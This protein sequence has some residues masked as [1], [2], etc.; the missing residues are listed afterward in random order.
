MMFLPGRAPGHSRAR[1]FYVVCLGGSTLLFAARPVLAM[2]PTQFQSGF[3][4]QGTAHAPNA[5]VQALNALS[6]EQTLAAGKYWVTVTLNRQHF[7]QHELRFEFSTEHQRLQPCL[8]PALL[9]QMGVRL[10]SLAEPLREQD[11]CLAL[12]QRIPQARTE[13]DT[14]KLALSISIP[15]VHMNRTKAGQ[16]APSQWDEGINA[17]F[18]NYQVSAMQG[19]AR[20]GG[21]RSSDDVYLNSGLNLGAWRLRSNQSLRQDEH[22]RR[23]WSRAYAYAQRDLPGTW[24]TLRLGETFTG[25]EV[26]RSLPIKGLMIKS[27]P[28]MLADNLQGYAP[29]VRGMAMSRAR[30]EV[31]Q[32]G[33][34]IYSTYVSA[35]P[36]EIDDLITSGSGELEVILTEDDGQVRRFTQ[37]YSTINNL[38]REGVWQYSAAVGHYNG[39]SDDADPLL[40]QATLAKGLGWKSTVYGGLLASDFYRAGSLG[41]ARDMGSIGA[42]AF[43]ATRSDTDLDQAGKTSLQGMSYAL[44]YGK[45]F[46]SNTTLRFAGYRYSTEGYRDFDEA[47][48]QRHSPTT[49]RGSRRSRLEASLHQRVGQASSVSL[50]LSDQDYWNSSYRQRQYQFNFST[51]HD[52]VT[53]NFYA[54]QSLNDTSGTDRQFG[55]SIS[56]P[57]QWRHSSNATFDIY[58]NGE[59]YSQRASLGGSLDENRLS[60]RIGANNEFN[61]TQSTSLSLGYQGAL[62]SVGAGVTQGSDYRSAS[63][64]ASGA[65]LL[66]A[67]GLEMGSSLGETNA[68]VQVPGI[69]G[70]GVENA[71][72]ARTNTRGFALVPHL[73]PYR[74][75]AVVLQV[76][77]LEPDI[78]I[79]NGIN[80]VVPRRG[81][82][83]K[84][85]FEARKV[86][87][88]VITAHTVAGLALP[89]GAQISD[90][91]GQ[92]IG[93]VGQAGQ[94][95]LSMG[96]Q[97]QILEVRWGNDEQP[98][99]RL[100]IDPQTTQARQGYRL[101]TL[102]CR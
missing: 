57:L 47:V 28:G 102:T 2:V 3:M 76:G 19:S 32:N 1:L 45:A 69:A 93:M 89:F 13:F 53:Y 35:G 65:L 97:S 20:Q 62:A 43:D 46:S 58:N 61:R 67:E 25:G 84:T 87:R 33:Y 75:N 80:Q 31:L 42:V 44:R 34:P 17:A 24:G 48:R 85:R 26:F 83:V 96:D 94:V 98:Q 52:K 74:A 55:L 68:L 99:C 4:R 56:V 100:H 70:V 50:T 16:I 15:Q 91:Q 59:R 5:G 78:E 39:A 77:E 95:M 92:V 37:P 22:G 10:N 27:D 36:Y 18:I 82:V 88:L 86:N 79:D 71:I 90:A 40:W 66:H 11:A 60:Y 30:L 73:R 101:Q 7:G 6:R 72:G 49:F 63:L 81:A 41:L 23:T 51:H 8:S 64:N 14:G 54:S 29:V 21:D 38:L 9:E 12:E